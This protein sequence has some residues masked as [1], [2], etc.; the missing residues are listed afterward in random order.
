MGDQ[1]MTRQYKVRAF[2]TLYVIDGAGRV[3]DA[4]EA[5]QSEIILRGVLDKALGQ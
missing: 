1:A 4:R 5:Q 3:L 2:P